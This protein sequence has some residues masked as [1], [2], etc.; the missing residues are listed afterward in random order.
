MVYSAV[1]AFV[2]VLGADTLTTE[3]CVR[4]LVYL[5]LKGKT[6]EEQVALLLPIFQKIAIAQKELERTGRLD[7][8]NGK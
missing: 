6:E 1:G 7:I 4:Q 8:L 5:H 2:K 3:D